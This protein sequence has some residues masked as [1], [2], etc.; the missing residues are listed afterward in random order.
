MM[1]I[2]RFHDHR[3]R[4]RRRR[5]S[6]EIGSI[7]FVHGDMLCGSCCCWFF[8]WTRMRMLRI[9]LEFDTPGHVRWH[10]L[11]IPVEYVCMYVCM[12]WREQG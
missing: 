3:R 9:Q 1:N 12:Y 5:Q 4:R 11:L 6:L 7:G 8:F 2:G 10:I